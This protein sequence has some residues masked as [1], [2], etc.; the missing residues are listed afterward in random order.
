MLKTLVK[1]QFRELFR[2]YYV[3]AKTG[4]ARGKSGVI[5]MFCLFAIVM[6]F[7]AGYLGFVDYMLA[8]K[9]MA[10]GRD[11]LYFSLNAVMAV[12]LGTFGSVFNT[13]STLYIAKDN[14]LLLS[15]P[16]PPRV[17]LTSRL[18][19][20]MAMSL[21]YSGVVW[22]PAVTVYAILGGETDA[23]CMGYALYF[24][25]GL[26][27]TA[28]TALL[29]WVVAALSVRLKGKSFVTVL[30]S[31][32]AVGVYYFFILRSG[33][34]VSAITESGDALKPAFM[35]WGFL[36]Y[37]LALGATGD[38]A[39][40]LIFTGITLA[41]AA[42]TIWWLSLTFI[43]IATTKHGGSKAVYRERASRAKSE[44]GALFGRELKRF[45][46][47]ATYML[48]AG[49]GIVFMVALAVLAVL[50]RERIDLALDS[51]FGQ[52]P[53]ALV[54]L[55]S[56][57][58]G[59]F[60]ILISMNFI[61]APSV[62]LEGERIWVIQSLPVEA[63]E[64]LRAKLRLHIVLN[65]VPAV[66]LWAVLMVILAMEVVSGILVLLGALLFCYLSGAFGL[67]LG[68]RR[69]NLHWTSEAQPIKQGLNV[70]I[71]MFGGMILGALVGGLYLPMVLFLD[72]R[73]Y[74]AIWVV[75]F[76]ILDV[77]LGRWLSRGGARLFEELG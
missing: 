23:I 48:N 67:F 4:K 17:I 50:F 11:W 3:S 65:V 71:I 1:K 30:I 14:E 31:L 42:V 46:S 7:L 77:L 75:L 20:V 58:L 33:N 6:L 41:L 51:V 26:F 56:M 57:M 27:V 5:A 24:V 40:F 22:L 13:F 52:A 54:I 53:Q 66:I 34:L 74:L 45:T 28:V 15:L 39:G 76:A 47:S 9:L 70:F 68:L 43:R 64:V 63:K 60:V 36:F 2:G 8:P 35:T 32:A 29:G 25:L 21:L 16:I 12:A 61:S 72:V 73:I 38:T 62:S 37:Q 59:G 44:G 19:S 10:A 69:P 49:F 55:Y 18:V